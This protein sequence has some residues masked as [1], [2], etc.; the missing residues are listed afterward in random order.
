MVTTLPLD[1]DREAIHHVVQSGLP[2]ISNLR[3]QRVDPATGC[4]RQ[5]P[6][7]A[8]QQSCLRVERERPAADPREITRLDLPAGWMCL[9]S[10]RAGYHDRSQ[11]RRRRVC[12][13]DQSSRTFCSGSIPPI[14]DGSQASRATAIPSYVGFSHVRLAGW[15]VAVAIPSEHLARPA[16]PF[17]RPA[18]A[19][20]AWAYW[21]WRCR[22]PADRAARQRPIMRLVNQARAV[23]DRLPVRPAADRT[24]GRP[25]P[26]QQ[27]FARQASG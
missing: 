24:C 15:S 25:T 26:W 22:R 4:H 13:P 2:Y 27:H 9:V 6:G 19:G 16:S 21:P 5:C 23:G 17:V 12:R 1:A 11:P 7:D 8:R 3:D 14:R 20:L 10:D 18:V